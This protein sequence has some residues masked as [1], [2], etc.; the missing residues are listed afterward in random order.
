[1]DGADSSSAKDQPTSIDPSPTST[2]GSLWEKIQSI[3]DGARIE[4]LKQCQV[5]KDILHQCQAKKH[6]RTQ[7]ED[8]PMGI[9]SVRVFDWRGYQHHGTG[10]CVREEHA[11][12]TCRGV[13]LRCGAM[14]DQMKDCFDQHGI[15]NILSQRRRVDLIRLKKQWSL[16]KLCSY[17]WEIVS[18][19]TQHGLKNE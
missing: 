8:V 19:R 11:L 15:E 1:M 4:R 10:S 17:S 2:Y 18:G 5:L 9:R 13:C 6:N 16:V 14:V 3:R 12:W 7:L